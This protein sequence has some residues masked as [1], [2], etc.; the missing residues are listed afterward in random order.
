MPIYFTSRKIKLQLT[1]QKGSCLAAQKE[2]DDI[3]LLLIL[4]IILLPEKIDMGSIGKAGKP[5]SHYYLCLAPSNSPL[6]LISSKT[7][8]VRCDLSSCNSYTLLTQT[9]T[10]K[11]TN[12]VF[13][14]GSEEGREIIV[15]YLNLFHV[16]VSSLA[17]GPFHFTFSLNYYL[18]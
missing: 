6:E 15:Y 2:N 10:N 14:K 8:H 16:L 17:T 18:R 7:N 4:T 12:N 5:K 9:H 13:Q 1:R 11:Q 3:L